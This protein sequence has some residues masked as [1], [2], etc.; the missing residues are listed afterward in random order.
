M[1]RSVPASR[2]EGVRGVANAVL[3][4]V[5]AR[6]KREGSIFEEVT[7]GESEMGRRIGGGVRVRE[8]YLLPPE[9]L[10]LGIFRDLRSMRCDRRLPLS[11]T[12]W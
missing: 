5:V 2:G 9:V 8:R 3:R 7:C 10:D 12:M 11:V 1:R 4:A 6:R